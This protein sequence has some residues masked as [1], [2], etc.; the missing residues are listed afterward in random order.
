MATVLGTVQSTLLVLME[1]PPLLSEAQTQSLTA[2]SSISILGLPAFLKHQSGM[3]LT[4]SEIH[5]GWMDSW[6]WTK[7]ASQEAGTSLTW[8]T[9]GASQRPSNGVPQSTPDRLHAQLRCERIMTQDTQAVSQVRDH[10]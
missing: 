3:P 6:V 8:I 10:M 9:N 2:L 5:Q 1:A 7:R 4:K